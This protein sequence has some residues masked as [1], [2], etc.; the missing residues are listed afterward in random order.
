MDPQGA[1]RSQ[2]GAEQLR[3]I[4]D[5]LMAHPLGFERLGAVADIA[6]RRLELLDALDKTEDGWP[7]LP[8]MTVFLVGGG[9]AYGNGAVMTGTKGHP[10]KTTLVLKPDDGTNIEHTARLFGTQEAAD[11]ARD[12]G[13][14]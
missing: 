11:R 10:L 13:K 4:S 14:T 7:L 2:A 3:R 9:L 12:D 6:I 5:W 1:K 8:G